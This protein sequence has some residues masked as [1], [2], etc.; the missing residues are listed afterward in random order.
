M[1]KILEQTTLAELEDVL[2]H[3][4]RK[5]DE[6]Y[7]EVVDSITDL[8]QRRAR[9]AKTTFMW[10]FESA[11][12]LRVVEL[13]HALAI[14][15]STSS[16]DER[17]LPSLP[18]IETVCK[19]LLTV[20]RTRE[21][22]AFLHPTFRDFL[23]HF[24]DSIIP[25]SKEIVARACTTY[26]LF[27]GLRGGPCTSQDELAARLD[28]FPLLP[29][30]CQYWGFHCE[31]YWKGEVRDSAMRILR[32]SSLL[33]S[34]CQVSY[35][36]RD[37]RRVLE[38]FAQTPRGMSGLHVASYYGLMEAAETIITSEPKSVSAVD[39]WR[40]TPLHMAAENGHYT[41]AKL[42]LDHQAST[43]AQ[44]GRGQTPLHLA[45]ARGH[46]RIVDLLISKDANIT[47]RDKH[48]LTALDLAASEGQVNVVKKLLDMGID[49]KAS[50]DTL[51][52][53]KSAI[54][55]A[56]ASGQ[57]KV[58]EFLLEK[59]AEPDAETLNEAAN[60]GLQETVGMLLE[61]GVSPNAK[62]DK[63]N[64]PLH[65]AA[66]AGHTGVVRQLIESGADLT[67]SDELDKTP[68]FL[69]VANGD[70]IMV[71]HLL[72]EGAEIEARTVTGETALLHAAATGKLAVV[73][74]L[75][76]YGA[77]VNALRTHTPGP[78]RRGTDS[79]CE[80]YDSPLQAAAGQGHD[81]I[82]E[83]LLVHGADIEI[84]DDHKRRPLHS[85]ADEGNYIVVKHLIDRSCLPD[86]PEENGRRPL[87]LAARA[88]KLETVKLLLGNGNVESNAPDSLK[89]TPLSYACE[90]QQEDVV[91]ALLGVIGHADQADADGRTP[92]S[93]AAAAGSER[94]VRMLLKREEVRIDSTDST[95]MTPVSYALRNGHQMVARLLGHVS[96]T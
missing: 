25:G 13:R 85:A 3:L 93:Y 17:H 68:L 20:D 55:R 53:S 37:H 30:M 23:M 34:I 75:L 16:L 80:A 65:V 31:G 33:D 78:A 92:L 29:Y 54:R 69:A 86:P 5:E 19:Q 95:G 46:E 43:E 39:S 50:G 72:D 27:E 81:E 47:V 6:F 44:N 71:E 11:R 87:H 70:E 42:L 2:G 14:E 94:I 57:G 10:L 82:V 32:D 8:P 73:R 91:E 49:K 4:P 96:R 63:Q 28:K 77:D 67:A 12:P 83:E 90:N 21:R 51:P 79:P 36:T 62:G 18:T 88:G 64:T 1:K 40:R 26:L 76:S 52:P 24:Q 38:K 58:V 66:K 56:A 59:G 74:L 41:L 84:E 48:Q 9:L 61:Y 60:S 22:I 15:A 45:A 35:T 89:R 7:R